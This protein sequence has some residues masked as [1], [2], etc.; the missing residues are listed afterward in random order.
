MKV[1]L[2]DA[3]KHVDYDQ[4]EAWV[5]IA[6]T[7][8]D[9]WEIAV[10]A[11]DQYELPSVRHGANVTLADVRVEELGTSTETAPRLAFKALLRG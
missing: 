2:L 4:T 5:V 7:P 8:E 1:F 9:A 3:S 10:A 6:A 11:Q